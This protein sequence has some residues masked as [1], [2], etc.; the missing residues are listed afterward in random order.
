MQTYQDIYVYIEQFEGEIIPVGFEL[1]GEGKR[2][3]KDLDCKVVAILIGHN[4]GHLTEV[5]IQYGAD[6]VIIASEKALE[7]YR[8]ES[9]AQVMVDIIEERKPEILLI[10]A[11]SIGRDL[12]PRVSAR[13]KTGLTADCTSLEICSETG[14]L[15]M[16]RPAFGGNILA[17]IV[18]SN[19]R[20][21][22]ATVRSGVMEK[23]QI[24]YQREGIVYNQK[25][26]LTE[27]ACD[28]KILEVIRSIQTKENL[29]DAEIIVAGGRGVGSEEGFF[30]LRQLADKLKGMVAGSRAAVDSGW[31][32]KHNQ[33]G[34][35]GTTV[36]PRVYIAC[37]ISGA[38]QHVAGMERSEYIVA[39]NRDP[40]APIF[41]Y[42]DVGIVGDLHDVLPK[43]IEEAAIC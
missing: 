36:R 26:K 32:H 31:I 9:Y 34:Q 14:N 18:C 2:L 13:I 5:L 37:G 1:I 30:L 11:T 15:L 43:L 10:G 25:V 38:I 29:N 6:E 16:T 41:D 21:Q 28:M 24:D 8:T 3:A 23:C 33:V 42:C 7:Y 22:M 39:I 17:T 35:T 40:D 20:P 12:A 4:V 19:F 27:D